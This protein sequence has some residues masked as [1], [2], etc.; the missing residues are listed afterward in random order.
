MA[1]KKTLNPL[2]QEPQTKSDITKGFMLAYMK[3]GKPSKEQ[4]D[5]FKEVVKANQKE[6]T[7]PKG[8]KYK[9][10]DVPKVRE[11]FCKLF[12]K[13]LIETRKTFTDEILS[14]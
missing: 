10:I 9:D 14:L 2:T 7:S 6:Y 13:H 12:F 4:I 1:K 8:E 11:E 5:K 3:S